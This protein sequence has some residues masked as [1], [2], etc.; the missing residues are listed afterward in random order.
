[1]GYLG[2][3]LATAVTGIFAVVL[4]G[5]SFPL[6]EYAPNLD[7]TFIIVVPITWF[8]TLMCF[9]AQKST[10][11]THKH[12][13]HTTHEKKSLN[14]P[15]QVSQVYTANGKQASQSEIKEEKQN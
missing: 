1:M 8:L 5:L 9:L 2:N 3:H 12:T 14:Q 7:L 10:D 13:S 6:I 15:S 11:Y 4:T